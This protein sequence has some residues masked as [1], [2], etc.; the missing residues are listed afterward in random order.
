MR[1]AER[2]AA[3]RPVVLEGIDRV[4]RFSYAGERLAG[5][6][7]GPRGTGDFH[8]LPP[9]RLLDTREPGEGPALAGGAVRRLMATGRCG[10]P[11][12]A[13]ALAVNVTAVGASAAGHLVARP[14]ESAASQV[15]TLNFA[16][17]GARANNAILTL[18]LEGDLD[19]VATL[20]GV[21]D[22]DVIVDVTG[23][24]E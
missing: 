6:T 21:G 3:G 8:T 18:G 20:A 23:Y 12:G 24:F 10:I 22:V 9:C 1:I 15:S 7:Q 4:Y 2:D 5:V 14:A 17:D 16:G 19:L 11:A 13:V